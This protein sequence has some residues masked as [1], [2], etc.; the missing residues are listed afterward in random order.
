MVATNSR[1]IPAFL[2][3][4][5]TGSHGQPAD[6]LLHVETIAARS[7]VHNWKILPHLHRNIHQLL[8][9][10]RGGGEARTE[11]TTAEFRAPAIIVIPQS[12][13]HAFNFLPD[14]QGFVASIADDVL[15]DCAQRERDALSLFDAPQTLQLSTA[16]VNAT[17]LRGAFQ[18]F[19]REFDR[20]APGRLAALEALLTLILANVLRLSHTAGHIAATSRS[21]LLVGRFRELVEKRYRNNIALTDYATALNV[22]VSQ[23]RAAC[24]KATTQSPM[25]LVYA[26]VL[27][28]AKRQLLYTNLTISEIGY[29]LGFEDAAYFTRFFT[30]RAGVSPRRFRQHNPHG[31]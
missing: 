2:L 19:A 30:S 13:V 28:E 8:L 22:S 31:L 7:R 4:G 21:H 18:M 5:E 16:A 6:R 26:R 27:L 12:T 25:R 3:Y 10:T 9:V 20:L 11:S 23:L 1:K 15:R 29:D 14:T 24:L 17:D